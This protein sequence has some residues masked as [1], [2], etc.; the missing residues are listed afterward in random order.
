MQV[1]L[2]RTGIAT[3]PGAVF[4]REGEGHLRMSFSNPIEVLER[5]VGALR[6]L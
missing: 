1:L 4:G 5:A 3:V 2:D 6:G